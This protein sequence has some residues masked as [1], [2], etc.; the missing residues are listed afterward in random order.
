MRCL[1]THSRVRVASPREEK[2]QASAH[3]VLEITLSLS[4]H[5]TTLAQATAKAD[6]SG[7]GRSGWVRS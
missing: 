2:L 6:Q 3:P 5:K 1:R 7:L 4:L